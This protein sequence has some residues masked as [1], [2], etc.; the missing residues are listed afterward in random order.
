MLEIYKTI[1]K[2]KKEEAKLIM[3]TFIYIFLRNL[4]LEKF[5]SW[6][7][8][9]FLFEIYLTVCV[10][11]GIKKSVFNEY[12]NFS[13]I[14]KDGF[15]YLPSILFY[16]IFIGFSIAII[17]LI[18]TL[19]IN[20]IKTHTI[21]SFF[22][23]FLIISWASFPIFFLILTLYAPFIIIVKNET[24]F[25]GMKESLKFVKRNFSDLICLFFPFLILWYIFVVIFQKY[26]KIIPLKT[27][28]ILLVSLNEILTVKLVFLTIKGVKNERNV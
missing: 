10:Y 2:I 16:Y 5:L 21:F 14:F 8:F 24:I 11:S 13:E 9:T 23:F 18:I 19:L 17:Y 26:D 22:L 15:Y 25:D 3:I 7:F 28:L 12:F 4:F 20:S 6:Y 1:L 27:F